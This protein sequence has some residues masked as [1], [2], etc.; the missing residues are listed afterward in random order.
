MRHRIY[1]HHPTIISLFAL[2]IALTSAGAWAATQLPKNSVGAQQIKPGAIRSAELHRNAV[3]SSDLSTSSVQSTDLKEGAV[4]STDIGTGE[5]E[6]Q[7]V[8]MPDPKQLQQAGS[9]TANV[10][11]DFGLVAT[12][13]TYTKAD[14]ASVLQ[15]DW[16]G[17]VEAPTA[18]CVF[19]LRV[20]G[21]PSAMGA[22]AIFVQ[23]GTAIS[24]SASALFAG[25]PSGL[26]TIEVW[27]RT[28]N[29]GFTDPCVVGP[30]KAGIP[31]TFIA[32]EQ[33]V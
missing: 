9:T 13:G 6:P 17:T 25:L 12:A 18:S 2:V 5:V 32:S 14:G 11:T 27:A 7:D 22:G 19:Q 3:K 33:V 28:P 8:T 26:H 15:V 20:D 1:K 29:P 4:Q 16:T 24:V 23:I 10:G 30:E 21:Q 31:Q